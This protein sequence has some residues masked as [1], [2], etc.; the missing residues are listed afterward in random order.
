[1]GHKTTISGIL[2]QAKFEGT[3]GSRGFFLKA[4]LQPLSHGFLIFGD[5][6]PQLGGGVSQALPMSV[7]KGNTSIQWFHG[8][9]QSKA[10]G[11]KT[12]R[13]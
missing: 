8:F 1:M 7:E 12:A 13:D 9:K 3:S 6:E 10:I 2:D 4:C 11:E 5:V